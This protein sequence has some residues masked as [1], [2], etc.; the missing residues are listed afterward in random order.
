MSSWA[1]GVAHIG[2]G[3]H[4]DG[5]HNHHAATN[6]WVVGV[7]H[8]GV[9]EVKRGKGHTGGHRSTGAVHNCTPPQCAN[10]IRRQCEAHAFI[11]LWIL[12]CYYSSTFAG[13]TSETVCLSFFAY[14]C[15][16]VCVSC[17]CVYTC[18]SVFVC[19]T[20][21]V[22]CIL[23]NVFGRVG[24]LKRASI[25]SGLASQWDDTNCSLRRRRGVSDVWIS[26]GKR[27]SEFPSYFAPPPLPSSPIKDCLSMLW[28]WQLFCVIK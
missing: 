16:R 15:S 22:H 10:D 4:H 19:V 28:S 18:A 20:H 21:C 8:L 1:V 5:D 13:Q 14:D 11:H 3:D 7:V 9:V 23:R 12:L 17:S 24:H 27:P 2:V 26:F 25:R 6:S